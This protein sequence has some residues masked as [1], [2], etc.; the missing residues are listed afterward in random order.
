MEKLNEDLKDTIVAS[1]MKWATRREIDK[2]PAFQKTI[3]QL[4]KEISD[5]SR[6]IESTLAAIKED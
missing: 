5:L 3:Q 1:I 6:S 2:D 4:S